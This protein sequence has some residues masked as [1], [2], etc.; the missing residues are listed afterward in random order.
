MRWRLTTG[1]E[2][3][4]NCDMKQPKSKAKTARRN[5]GRLQRLVR[6][7]AYTLTI[8]DG[9]KQAVNPKP[10]RYSSPA[11]LSHYTFI[12]NQSERAIPVPNRG[13]SVTDIKTGRSIAFGC[14]TRQEAKKIAKVRILTFGRKL[15][16][17]RR[18]DFAI[19]PNDRS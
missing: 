11:W 10:F 2:T 19:C 16:L 9:Q 5:P 7:K 8:R 17:K 14:D 13:F 18:R 3:P 12:T 1:A 4:R 15:F 6:A